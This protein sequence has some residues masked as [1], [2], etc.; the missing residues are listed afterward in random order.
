MVSTNIRRISPFC[1]AARVLAVVLA[2]VAV[3]PGAIGLDADAVAATATDTCAAAKVRA[4]GKRVYDEAKCHQKALL[5]ATAVDPGCIAR[6]ETRFLA[7]LAKADL[8]VACQGTAAAFDTIV[9]T[10]VESIATGGVTTTTPTT[11]TT[12][13]TGIP[14]ASICCQGTSLCIQADASTPDGCAAFGTPVP[15]AA[16]SVCGGTTGTC[17]APPVTGGPCCQIDGLFCLGGPSL[18]QAN[19]DS[20]TGTFSASATCTPTGCAQ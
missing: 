15:G 20:L 9:G 16:G 6:A 14:G 18:N 8:A 12:S 4:A 11:T 3:G 1:P 13:T 2:S 5:V 10:C 19:C 7:A 17:D